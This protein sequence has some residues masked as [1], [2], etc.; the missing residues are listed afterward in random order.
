ME[1]EVPSEASSLGTGQWMATRAPR[2]TRSSLP[3]A[4]EGPLDAPG[5]LLRNSTTELPALPTP[6]E[7]PT[8][9]AVW[10]ASLP[11][12]DTPPAALDP[13]QPQNA[14]P[15]PSAP[16]PTSLKTLACGECL[17]QCVSGTMWSVCVPVAKAPVVVESK[18]F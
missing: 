13:T 18:T 14:D 17:E 5:R 11:T 15:A 7:G 6:A 9:Q 16:I 4:M 12:W 3:G 1:E 2:P 8:G 10:H